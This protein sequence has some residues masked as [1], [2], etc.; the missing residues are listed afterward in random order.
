MDQVWTVV[1]EPGN[2]LSPT[3]APGSRG[4]TRTVV[5]LTLTTQPS[6]P[7]S[8][9]LPLNP[10]VQAK[11]RQRGFE[12]TLLFCKCEFYK[13]LHNHRPRPFAC[14]SR[15]STLASSY[16]H[17]RSPV[18][19]SQ[20]QP[21]AETQQELRFPPSS[22]KTNQ[23]LPWLRANVAVCKTNP[24]TA[25]EV[26][27]FY[28]FVFNSLDYSVP[29]PS[30]APPPAPLKVFPQT[31]RPEDERSVCSQC[32]PNVQVKNIYTFLYLVLFFFVC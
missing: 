22:K 3:R 1:S 18:P 31:S 6:P 19:W 21:E 16:G 25:Q 23:H 17:A 2:G 7:A 12:L 29:N 9:G 30:Q 28:L 27:V 24:S 5:T 14:P 32:L 10:P 15:I 11:R 20:V 8:P 4:H 26:C 13:A